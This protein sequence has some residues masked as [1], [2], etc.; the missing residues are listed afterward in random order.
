MHRYVE[1]FEAYF[2]H[3]TT[4]W[5]NDLYEHCSITLISNLCRVKKSEAEPL[6]TVSSCDEV[7]QPS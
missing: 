4:V 3:K 6:Q 2:Y 7:K 1:P 5:N